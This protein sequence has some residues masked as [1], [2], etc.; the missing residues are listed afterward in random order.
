MRCNFF[1]SPIDSDVMQSALQLS[2]IKVLEIIV[3]GVSKWVWNSE[4]GSPSSIPFP[5]EGVRNLS[6]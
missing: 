2:N 1:L 3:I 6:E 4:Y 5:K